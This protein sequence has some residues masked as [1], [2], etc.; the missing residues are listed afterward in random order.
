MMQH[1]VL[2]LPFLC[3]VSSDFHRGNACTQFG[4]SFGIV[5]GFRNLNLRPQPSVIKRVCS[6]VHNQ[7]NTR[8]FSR[9][10][11]NKYANGSLLAPAHL[12]SSACGTGIG[13]T[14]GEAEVSHRCSELLRA[15]F[16]RPSTLEGPV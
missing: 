14:E 13:S 7:L 2:L 5:G 4:F 11:G 3:L 10:P 15:H 9:L 1:R 12:A 16:A 6:A 8:I